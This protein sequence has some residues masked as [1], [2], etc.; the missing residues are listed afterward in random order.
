MISNIEFL[1]DFQKIIVL[2]KH[3]TI[4]KITQGARQKTGHRDMGKK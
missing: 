2:L 4:Y 1:S 3:D